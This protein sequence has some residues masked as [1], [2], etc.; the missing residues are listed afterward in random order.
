[1]FLTMAGN[2]YKRRAFLNFCSNDY[3]GMSSNQVLDRV[4][5]ELKT[6]GFGSAGAC[7]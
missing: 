7:F 3:L 5:R 1:M 4:S 6:F 2:K